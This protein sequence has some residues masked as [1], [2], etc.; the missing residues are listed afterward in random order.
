MIYLRSLCTALLILTGTFAAAYGAFTQP[1]AINREH[2]VY[3]ADNP[4]LVERADSVLNA[5]RLQLQNLLGQSLDYKAEV[6]IVGD[7][8]YFNHLIGGRFPHWGAAVAI[9]SRRMIIIKSPQHF[10]INKPLE[11]LL[12]HEYAHLVIDRRTGYHRA[13]RWFNEG[14]AMLVS[15]EWG[16]SDN[17][18]MGRAAIFGDF[19]GL[20]EI[21]NVN[22]F[23]ESR[24]H[25]AYAQSYLSVQYMY[26]EYGN[27]MVNRFLDVLKAGGS[28]DEALR[29]ATG[30]DT[31]EFE[32]ELHTYF[33]R[34]FNLT[35]L[36]MDTAFFWV[37][38]AVIVIVAFVV[39]YNRRRKFYKKWE[40]EEKYQST[41]FDYGDPDNP[42][43]IDD[44]DEPWR[45]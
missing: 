28:Q 37:G 4:R 6:H 30:A 44:D 42:E 33:R 9:P 8:N 15:T 24:A 20:E 16:W 21:E 39:K 18:A 32:K 25:V 11:H 38:L 23:S 26:R 1:E 27:Q 31:E 43:K 40:E 2:F 10:N 41:D 29:A 5:T 45:S 34:Q 14:I 3:Y 19:I 13:P 35:S 17:L 22:R 36:L 12:A 7:P